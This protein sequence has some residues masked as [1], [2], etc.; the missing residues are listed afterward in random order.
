MLITSG[1]SSFLTINPVVNPMNSLPLFIYTSYISHEPFAITRAFGAASVL[2]AIVLVLFV[3]VRLL[4][5]ERG[6][7]R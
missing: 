2:L 7:R 4:A 6:V 5:R 3:V 1:A